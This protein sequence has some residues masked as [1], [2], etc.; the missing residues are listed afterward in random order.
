MTLA[1]YFTSTWKLVNMTA[2]SRLATT[3]LKKRP[4]LLRNRPLKKSSSRN[5]LRRT[6]TTKAGASERNRDVVSSPWIG[7]NERVLPRRARKKITANQMR[8]TTKVHHLFGAEMKL[9][10]VLW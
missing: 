2:V 7:K 1:A 4:Y 8:P 6:S 3:G 5:P 10:R 9:Y